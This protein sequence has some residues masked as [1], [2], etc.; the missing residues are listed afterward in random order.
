MRSDVNVELIDIKKQFGPKVLFSGLNCSIQSGDCLEISGRN[1]SG[2]STLL[3][4]IAGLSRPSA[5]RVRIRLNGQE[6]ADTDRYR[7]IGMVSP[8]VVMYNELTGVENIKFLTQVRGGAVSDAEI[9]QCCESVG[10]NLYKY[11]LAQT[12][13]TGMKQRLKLAAMLTIQPTLWLLD[14]PASNLDAE[15]R[16]IVAKTIRFAL[17][18]GAAVV[19]ASNEPWEA[20]YANQKIALV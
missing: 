12:Y 10:L 8:E 11:S 17:G 16:L 5:G 20:S 2:K 14:E 9:A 4:I 6:V 1:G 3:K 7:L 18:Y 13:S 19:I 15:G